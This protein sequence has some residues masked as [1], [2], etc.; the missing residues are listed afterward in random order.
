MR[1]LSA[2]SYADRAAATTADETRQCNHP[3]GEVVTAPLRAGLSLREL[4]E[5]DESV[6]PRWPCLEPT[7][8]GICR[9][10]RHLPSLPLYVHAARGQ[11]S[12]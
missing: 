9:M 6:L 11:V 8:S 10:L 4:R 2:G 7:E 12:V 3:L 5:S 1:H